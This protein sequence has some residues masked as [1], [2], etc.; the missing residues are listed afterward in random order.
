MRRA[1]AALATAVLLLAAVLGWSSRIR[2]DDERKGGEEDVDGD[3]VR[4]PEFPEG[5]EWLNAGR[6][7]SL[8]ELRGRVVLLDFWT[9]C[10]INCI[11]IIPDLR[12]LE[13]KYARQ[14][15]VVIG[16]HSAK[17]DNE[18][19]ARNIRQAILRYE[20]EHPVVVD[21][22][23]RIWREYGVHAWPTQVLI[24]P[25]GYVVGAVSGEGHRDG[26]DRA[27]GLLL[28][29]FEARGKLAKGPL[30]LEAEK[31]ATSSPLR[32]P[33]KVAIDAG[34][35]RI[36]VADSNHN[37][38]VVAGLDGKA[39]ETFGSGRIG[40]EDGPPEGATFDHPQGLAF[41]ADGSLYVADTENHLI[42]RIDLEAGAVETVAG[43]GVQAAFRAGGGPAPATAISSPWDLLP[44]GDWLYI[45]M[46]GPHQVWRLHLRDRKLEV[47]AGTGRERC[48]DGARQAAAFAQPSGLA[49]DGKRLFVADSEVSSVRAVDLPETGD[50]VTTVAGSEELFGFGDGDGV[51]QAARLQ[52]CLGVAFE[53]GALYL[54][55][56]Y[57]HKVKKIDPASRKVE[58]LLG[59]GKPGRGLD[60][61]ELYEPGGLAVAAG[62]LYIADTN[63]H[64][65]VVVDLATKKATELA[66]EGL[67]ASAPAG[68]GAEKPAAPRMPPIRVP[69]Q[70][71]KPGARV[72]LRV[73]PM[74][75]PGEKLA[76]DAPIDVRL[77]P[78]GGPA[79]VALPEGKTEI[80]ARATR[81]PVEV[82]FETAKGPAPGVAVLDVEVSYLACDADDAEGAVCRPRGERYHVAV[83]LDA[84]GGAE[85]RLGG[86]PEGGR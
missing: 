8:R 79:L 83:R 10:C 2:G 86:R 55:D 5:N 76:P 7:L 23:M 56:T 42:R 16:V 24:D 15:F 22:E 20:V 84:A 18:G 64:R 62:K 17:F 61:L 37:R 77:R 54:A 82:S 36:A 9:Y 68:A 1:A 72:A 25:E 40:R 80:A 53:G 38:V 13:E 71:L 75:L 29:E 47:Y 78:V 21:R 70:A 52:H 32:F 44:A 28:K 14:P 73:E 48:T 65:I 6:A 11:H 59:T 35:G 60:P 51:G 3:R 74:P 57:N 43:T 67:A 19:D 26:I 30:A 33:G 12:Y 81:S 49:T 69:T 31:L 45:A 34:R 58:S 50:R 63:N 85:I 27:V 4:A 39:V 46:A 66:L 41:G